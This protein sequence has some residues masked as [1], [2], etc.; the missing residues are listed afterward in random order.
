MSLADDSRNLAGMAP[1]LPAR[2]FLP[3]R[4]LG[5]CGIEAHRY[6]KY[7]DEYRLNLK[8]GAQMMLL[9]DV[10]ADSFKIGVLPRQIYEIG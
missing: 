2:S 5:Y 9:V 3:V 6:T 1:L 8:G 4:L 7:K 10:I